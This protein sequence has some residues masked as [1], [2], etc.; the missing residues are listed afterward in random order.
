MA[1]NTTNYNIVKPA[2]TE[3]Y[4][5]AIVNSNSD[6]IDTA[7]GALDT[8][9]IGNADLTLGIISTNLFDKSTVVTGY[10][11]YGDGSFSIQANS[12]R[13]GYLYIYGLNNIY[14]SG[15]TPYT[16]GVGE[17]FVAFYNASK[18]FIAGSLAKIDDALTEKSLS[19]PVGAYYV[20]WSIYQRKSSGETVNLDTIQVE[21]GSSKTSYEP[22]EIG[23]I[24]IK[25]YSFRDNYG[26][27]KTEGK[28]LLIFGDS[29]TETATVSDDG[30]TYTEGTRSNWPFFSKKILKFNQMWNYAK[31]GGHYQDI[32]GLEPRQK[33]SVQ[34]T[35][36]IANN[37]PADII[38]VSAGINDVGDPLG[39]YATAMSKTT[40]ASLDKTL[41]YESIR[42][43]FWTLKTTY[44]NAVCFATLPV[45]SPTIDLEGSSAPVIEAITLM[46][47]RYNFIIID[48]QNESGIVKDFEVAGS[49]GRYLYDGLHPNVDGQV[50]IANLIDRVILNTLNY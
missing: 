33:L 47:K 50:M 20:A 11:V 21:S 17:S 35:T 32:V 18:V 23:V 28:N 29:I 41:L 49:T 31:S 13:S 5:V 14:F 27:L 44:P 40:L 25:D 16:S 12:A 43:A 2:P 3:N 6:I 38:V 48:G 10:E 19:V 30:A 45:Q 9:K 7:I 42:W 46:A 24:G 36:A 15:L 37:R 39:D 4:D 8:E 26:K 34:I 22:Y 1:T